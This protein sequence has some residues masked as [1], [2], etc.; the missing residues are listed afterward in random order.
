[1]HHVTFRTP[2]DEQRLVLCRN[3]VKARLSATSVIDRFNFHSIYFHESAGIL[4]EIATN[5]PGFA[6]DEKMDELGTLVR[7][8]FT[9]IIMYPAFIYKDLKVI[10]NI[11]LVFNYS[12]GSIL[13]V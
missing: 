8:F 11:S 1:V 2:T 3:I 10:G 5:T 7:P 13:W 4:F 9:T 6:V 12:L